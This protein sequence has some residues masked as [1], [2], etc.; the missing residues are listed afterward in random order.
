MSVEGR[1][2]S[3]GG[4]A[5]PGVDY[6][7]V[8]AP[9][10]GR[11]V[12][13]R[14]L[15]RRQAPRRHAR[16][17]GRDDRVRA[18][19]HRRR[20]ARDGARA[21]SRSPT[22][23]TRASRASWPTWA[24]SR[25]TTARATRA[26][27]ASPS[28]P[29]RVGEKALTPDG[30]FLWVADDTT[31]VRLRRDPAT[32]ALERREVLGHDRPGPRLRSRSATSTSL[33]IDVLDHAG[34]QAAD[35]PRCR[36]RRG[37]PGDGAWSRSR[38]TPAASRRSP[39][40]SARVLRAATRTMRVRRGDHL[41]RR[42][43]PDHG[44]GRPATQPR[45]DQRLPALGRQDRAVR[46]L[47][48]APGREQAVRAADDRARRAP[49]GR[50]SRPTA[51]RSRVRTRDHL[52]LLGW[53]EATGTLTP[54]RRLRARRR[55]GAGRR[56]SAAS[57]ARR[58]SI[59]DTPPDYLDGWGPVRFAPDGRA[60]YVGRAARQPGHARCRGWRTGRGRSTPRRASGIAET[61]CAVKADVVYKATEI[62]TSPDGGDVYVTGVDSGVLSLSADR[63]TGALSAPRC[64]MAWT[65][66]ASCPRHVGRRRAPAE[67]ERQHG[68]RRD[69]P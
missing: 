49:R 18:E 15:R 68:P 35:R 22:T 12:R 2:R 66:T 43:L 59:C 14:G 32:G 33:P 34:R 47:L 28:S 60:L 26:G 58:S 50:R 17:A 30:R 46:A 27:S 10:R 9:D 7:P 31:I 41:P 29:R 11:P 16:R 69:R 5:T 61:R 63:V 37:Q 52:A 55:A 6:E 20:A 40:A 53:D 21:R 3:V 56:P 65:G 44:P 23:T 25:A 45:R 48:R 42:A 64:T 62:I 19:R 1:L 24:A 38:W 36:L 51:R 4:T 39:A 54:G 8:D 67:R 13:Q 57:T